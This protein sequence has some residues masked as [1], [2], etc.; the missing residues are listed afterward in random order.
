MQHSKIVDRIDLND[1]NIDKVTTKVCWWK[2]LQ[3]RIFGQKEI[4]DD[5]EVYMEMYL[6]KGA[7]YITK[8]EDRVND[9]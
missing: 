6:Y 8:Y 7:H 5:E 4:I 2:T 3:A 1:P 9:K